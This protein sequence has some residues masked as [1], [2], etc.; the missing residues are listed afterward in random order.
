MHTTLIRMWKFLSSST[1]GLVSVAR[2][3]T[4]TWGIALVAAAAP[5]DKALFDFGGGFVLSH[6]P[7]Q[8]ARVFAADRTISPGLRVATGHAQPWPGIT[9]IAPAGSWDLSDFGQVALDLRNP[10]AYRVT[11]ACRVDNQ[12]ANGVTNCVTGTVVIEPGMATVLRVDLKRAGNDTLQG[13][14]FG[15]R[16]YPVGK[17]GEG[18]VDPARITQLVVFVPNPSA[19]H[20]FEV[21]NIRATGSYAPPTAT[22]TDA[23]PYF[24]LIDTLGQYRHKDWPG[25]V[26]SL[27]EL[28]QRKATEA[29]ELAAQPG[30]PEWDQY[31]GWKAGP[32][33]EATGFF[34][35]QKYQGKWWL[36]DPE[37]H[38]F[39][40]HGI[41]CVLMLDVTPIE[42][43]EG[44]FDQFPGELPE[45]REFL[46][47][48]ASCLKGHYAGKSP[49]SFSFAGA[50][51][52]R[53]Y[54]P[55][56]RQP[57]QER[58]HRRLRSWGLN[59]IGMWSDETVRL[60]RKTPYVDALNSSRSKP[61]EGSEG[62]WG[63]FPDPFDPEFRAGLRRGMAAKQGK[64]AGDPWCLG[65]FADNEIAWGDELSL[66]AATLASPAQQPAKQAFL[67]SLKEEYRDIE[68]L[69]AVWGTSHA[70]FADL[71]ENRTVPDRQKA[72]DDLAAF[73]TRIA[74]QYFRTIREVIRETAPKQLYLG[75]RFAWVSARAAAAAAK[76]CDVVSYNLYQRSVA[77]F[78]FDGGADVP[79]IIGEFHFGALDRGMFHTGLVPVAN[80]AARA[81]A[82]LEYVEGAL[83]HP[84]FVGCHW[85]QYQDE[86]TTGRVYDEENYQIGFVDITDTP[87]T[88][89]IEAAR[90]AGYHL[91]DRLPK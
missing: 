44:W 54:G 55:E 13:K 48:R 35:T 38:L 78:R 89:T 71:L 14:L 31:G 91:Y 88:E 28:D 82:Y 17:G 2:C 70:S 68:R 11:V 7:L 32:R 87:Y 47:P 16:G 84:D 18:T 46:S 53:K 1:P 29:A 79:L 65:F 27:G 49:R 66:A 86:P 45:L 5:G 77:D 12:G 61:I 81:A 42:E 80:Q 58:L 4:V 62:Y 39:F 9:L 40:S 23:S 25:K 43:R 57:Y 63:K 8:D 83:R 50:N 51:L 20:Q 69:N 60:L 34:R 19:D 76:Y 75:C 85:F 36:V 67:E 72:R 64:S 22:V 3:A 21:R 24:P 56:W 15:M 59:T 74:E 26:H 33:L 52:R 10:G 6:V 73:Y 90:Q 37:G 30:P 41:D